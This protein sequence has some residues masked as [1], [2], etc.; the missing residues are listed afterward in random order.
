MIGTFN[1]LIKFNSSRVSNEVDKL[2]Y[3]VNN[4]TTTKKDETF[5][6]LGYDYFDY[7]I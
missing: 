7:T 5:R 4:V 6:A 1:G 3:F 2:K